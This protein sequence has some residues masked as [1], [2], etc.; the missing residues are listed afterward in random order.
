MSNTADAKRASDYRLEFDYF[1]ALHAA[2]GCQCGLP[3]HC[4]HSCGCTV[5]NEPMTI[6][7]TN[8]DG[9]VDRAAGIRKDEIMREWRRTGTVRADLQP[10]CWVCNSGSAGHDTCPR[11]VWAGILASG[12]TR[13]AYVGSR[14]RWAGETR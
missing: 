7:H 4:Q 8:N 3:F 13:D 12:F 2:S 11:T 6:G 9:H 5:A 1:T 10:Q 14:V